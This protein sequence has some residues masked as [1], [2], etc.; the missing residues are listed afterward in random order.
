MAISLY[1]NLLDH[2]VVATGIIAFI[3]QF[4]RKLI[5]TYKKVT[6]CHLTA[7]YSYEEALLELVQAP[8]SSYTSA[9]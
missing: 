5:Y 4:L 8:S 7:T 1:Q 9:S 6:G 3:G 2:L